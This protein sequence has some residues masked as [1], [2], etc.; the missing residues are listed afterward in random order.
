MGSYSLW[1]MPRGISKVQLQK[2]I[3]VQA[4]QYNA[5]R[6]APHVTLLGGI[7]GEEDAIAAKTAELAG[8]IQV[9]L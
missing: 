4:R 8:S 1:L 7:G 9:G 2:E 6:F 5:P 3:D